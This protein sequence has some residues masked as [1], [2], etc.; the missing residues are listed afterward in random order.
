MSIRELNFSKPNLMID[1][2]EVKRMFEENLSRGCANA[3]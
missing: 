1:L 2:R 3:S